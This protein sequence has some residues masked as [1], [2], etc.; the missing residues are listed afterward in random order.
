MLQEPGAVPPVLF[1]QPLDALTPRVAARVAAT[2]L[3]GLGQFMV[4]HDELG[5]LEQGVAALF[6]PLPAS[7]PLPAFVPQL[8]AASGSRT[9]ALVLAKQL[10][11]GALAPTEWAARSRARGDGAGAGAAGGGGLGVD[12]G[13][14]DGLLGAGGGRGEGGGGGMEEDLGEDVGEGEGNGDGDAGE[15]GAGEEDDEDETQ[16]GVAWVQLIDEVDDDND[17]HGD[18]D[19]DDTGGPGEGDAMAA[20]AGGES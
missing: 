15:G 20:D 2:T 7:V 12:A 6:T 16:G 5:R 3:E 13:V 19:E 4:L 17:C 10:L 1:A 14:G 8:A 9:V 11:S 18:G